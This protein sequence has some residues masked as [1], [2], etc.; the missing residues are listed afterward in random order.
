MVAL[1][2]RDK[3]TLDEWMQSKGITSCSA[4]GKQA[5]GFAELLLLPG[6]SAWRKAV[7]TTGMSQGAI[8][9]DN[10][11]RL[12]LRAGERDFLRVLGKLAADFNK[13]RLGFLLM[14]RTA[15]DARPVV[16]IEC[17]NCGNVLLLDARKV[18]LIGGTH[19]PRQ[20][21]AD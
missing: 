7:P 9:L 19:S 4:C 5:F 15:P 2:E 17:G 12:G 1:G 18:G 21:D 3:R 16:K 11:Y 6:Y 8:S 14:G 13:L 10:P 20:G